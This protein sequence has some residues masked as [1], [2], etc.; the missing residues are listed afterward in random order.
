MHKYVGQ[1]LK[2]TAWREWNPNH[3]E[4]YPKL[5]FSE[6]FSLFSALHEKSEVVWAQI[7]STRLTYVERNWTNEVTIVKQ[8]HYI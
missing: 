6:V 2:A 7:F 8:S 5:R 4:I 1:G 3:Q